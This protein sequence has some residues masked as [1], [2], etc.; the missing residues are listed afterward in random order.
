MSES[1]ESALRKNLKEFQLKITS[2][3]KEIFYFERNC[4]RLFVFDKQIIKTH[5]NTHE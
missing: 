3:K 1:F 5:L 4:V 2:E